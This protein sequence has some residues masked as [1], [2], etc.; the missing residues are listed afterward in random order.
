MGDQATPAGG[1]LDWEE[2]G[3]I[4]VLFRSFPHPNLYAAR[5][6]AKGLTAY[7]DTFQAAVQTL[8]RLKDAQMKAEGDTSPTQ[9]QE[10]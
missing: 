4:V 3:N 1:R 10:D 7:G 9:I 2:I 5:L 8:L 6:R